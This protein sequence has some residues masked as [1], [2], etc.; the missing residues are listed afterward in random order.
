MQTTARLSPARFL[1]SA[2]LLLSVLL[3]S[4]APQSQPIDFP[5]LPSATPQQVPRPTA[6][7]T[8]PAYQPGTLVDYTAQTGDTLPALAVRFNTTVAE[9][10]TANPIVPQSA[11]SMPPGLPMK[12]PIY[13]RSLW[14]SPFQ[15]LPD[16]HFINGPLQV[17]FDARAFVESQPGWFKNYT[18][19]LG[20]QRR[21]GG[22]I[23]TYIA[24]NFSISPRLLLA[25][26]E[27]QSG[28]LTQSEMPTST[29]YL[30][31]YRDSLYSTPEEQ[32]IW[33]SN[34]LNDAYY[35]WRSGTLIEFEHL[36]GRLERPDPWQNAASVALQYYFSRTMDY[37]L[38]ALA[39]G[40]QGL[41]ATYTALFGNP[42]SNP[43]DHIPG[44]LT[45]P[46]MRLPFNPGVRWAYTG[47]PHTGW[48]TSQPY[49]AIDFA[50]PVQGCTTAQDWATAVA[51]GVISRVGEASLVLDL[52]G[53][54]DERTGWSVF[55]LHL[56]S[57]S[58]PA[59]GTRV[60]AGD[61]LGH[62]SCEGGR[63]TGSHVHI[64]RKYNG[65]WMLAQGVLGFN[66]EGWLAF[67]GSVAYEGTLVRYG[68][69]VRASTKSDAL[70]IISADPR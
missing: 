23:I 5:Y 61:P 35:R 70:S 57:A 18:A 25:V 42:W 8:R 41:L 11:T 13:Y 28:A 33:A 2:I 53:D 46:E 68:V 20:G 4:C 22:D 36:D 40:N 6:F 52:D 58:L 9:I 32:V 15:I 60:K 63:A 30:L 37:N 54:G 14:G 51:D 65:E 43:A 3:A 7:P 69:T 24:T 59:V 26:L 44:S 34:I 45:Q 12:M 39:T 62:P 17:G 38:Y 50:P 29:N 47:G 19:Y 10:L 55:Y 16:G 31:G 48:G 64:A 67:N 21:T 66:L 27:Y 1:L 56:A 49:A